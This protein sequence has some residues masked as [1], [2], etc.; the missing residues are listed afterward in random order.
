[1]PFS[2]FLFQGS[3]PPAVTT[4]SN[5]QGGLPLWYSSYLSTLANQA[6]T[7]AGQ[8]YTP[9]SGQRIA[10]MDPQ[11]Q[12]A[13]DYL[14]ANATNWQ[15][16][17]D[18]AQT[19]AGQISAGFDNQQFNQYMSPYIGGVVNEIGRL[20]NQNL[21]ENLL[22]TLN[23]QFVGAGQFGS[24]RN[25]TM[26][27]QLI[28]DTGA[29]ISGQQGMA[30]QGALTA[31]Q[32]GYNTGQANRNQAASNLGGLAQTEQGLTTGT[33]GALSASGQTM[34]NFNQA[35]LDLGYTDFQNQINYPRQNVNFMSS[36]LRG[37]QVPTSQTS[38][39]TAP[40]SGSMGPSPI[41]TFGGLALAG[42]GANAATGGYGK[43]LISKAQGGLSL[44]RQV[45][46]RMRPQMRQRGGLDLM[47]A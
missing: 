18:Q 5:A 6:S 10:D 2:D 32:Q 46:P 7:I 20:G 1:M 40:F 17:L 36:V 41:A 42:A 3:T 15:A 11:Q 31:A 39:N 4:E 33:A 43:E 13:H 24:A 14:G 35:G 28:R 37:T 45:R 25:A 26:D 21:N 23:S 19:N 9:Y 29:N 30:L 44:V 47:A 38:T 34:Q 16:P 12:Q 27:E 22:P 8:P